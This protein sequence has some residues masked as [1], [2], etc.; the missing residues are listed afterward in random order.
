MQE[1]TFTA[2]SALLRD[3][4][5]DLPGDVTVYTLT[6]LVEYLVVRLA[7]NLQDNL[8]S[9]LLILLLSSLSCGPTHH[10]MAAQLRDSMG[11]LEKKSYFVKTLERSLLADLKQG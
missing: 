10:I 3:L 7:S 11:R 5:P 2:K 8:E 1:V 6:Q 4:L 9:V